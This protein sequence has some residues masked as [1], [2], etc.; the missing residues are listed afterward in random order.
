MKLHNWPT[1]GRQ[2]LVQWTTW[3]FSLHQDCHPSPAAVC[4]QHRDQRI[5]LIIPENWK[6]Y[7]TQWRL[8]VTS[9]HAG[10]RCWQI[11]TSRQRGTVNQQTRRTRKIQRK[12][13]LFGC[14]PSESIQV[15]WRH[16]CS[17]IP[18]QERS[19]IRKATLQKWR[20]KKRKHSVHGYFRKKKK[21]KRS[22]CEQ[23]KVWWLDNSRARNPQRRTGISEQS[24]PIRCRSTSSRHSMKPCQTKTSQETE[25]DLRKLAETAAEA[26]S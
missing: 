21:Q 9:M 26:K 20:H 16:M 11:M 22:F 17:H 1:K 10:N 13:F 4:P 15:T 5:S 14:S 6:H 24:S 25:K 8:E 2:P 18:L 7:R 12:A 3:H 19:Q 23:K